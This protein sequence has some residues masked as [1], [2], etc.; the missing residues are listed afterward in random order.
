MW[1]RMTYL[2]ADQNVLRVDGEYGDLQLAFDRGA[3]WI[4][5]G[6]AIENPYFGSTMFDCG[7]ITETLKTFD[8]GDR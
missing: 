8:A 2:D 1:L 4:Q 7:R 3:E 6:T 5:A